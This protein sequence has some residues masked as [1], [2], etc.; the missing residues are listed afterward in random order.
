LVN[1]GAHPV[2]REYPVSHSVSAL[3]G[4]A[5]IASLFASAVAGAPAPNSDKSCALALD[6]YQASGRVAEFKVALRCDN[7]DGF[8][9]NEPIVIGLTATTSAER[10]NDRAEIEYDFPLQNAMIAPDTAV[11]TFTFHAHLGD[12]SGKTHVYAVAWPQS[13]LQDCAGGRSGCKRFGYALGF[14]E[15]LEK[16]CV[17][18]NESG[19]ETIKD[20]FRCNGSKDYRFKFR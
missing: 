2:A 15:N 3:F 9:I 17:V 5:A 14:P 8:P 11:M 13:F 10:Q 4:L 18:K 19:E 7:G 16:L 12:I 1:G 20:G 6:N